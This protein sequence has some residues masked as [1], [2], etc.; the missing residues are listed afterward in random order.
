MKYIKRITENLTENITIESEGYKYTISLGE[1]PKPGEYGYLDP[2]YNDGKK[3]IIVKVLEERK[4]PSAK[5]RW[6]S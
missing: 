4:Y 3:G 1:I 6:R 5:K 2:S